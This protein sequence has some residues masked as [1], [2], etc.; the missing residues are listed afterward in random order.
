MDAGSAEATNLSTTI[1]SGIPSFTEA[2]NLPI[3]IPG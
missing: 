2:I 3:F 1:N